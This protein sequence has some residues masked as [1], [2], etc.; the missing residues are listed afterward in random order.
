MMD[1]QT[2]GIPIGPDTSLVVAEILLSSVDQSM[3]N[4]HPDLISGFRYVDDYE[5]SF[6]KLS[7]G[8]QV[9]TELQGLLAEY[10]LILNPRKTTLESLPQSFEDTWAMNSEGSPFAALVIQ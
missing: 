10:E 3:L 7:E 4:S 2:H 8:E 6:S 1:G 9:L 5:L